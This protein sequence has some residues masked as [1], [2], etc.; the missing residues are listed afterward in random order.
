[1]TEPD[2]FRQLLGVKLEAARDGY[3][4]MSM[5]ITKAHLNQLGSAHGGAIFSLA[6]C[7]FGEAANQTDRPAVAIQVSINY[8][9]AACE[10]DLLVAEAQ[11]ISEGKTFCVYEV[12]VRK[13]DKAVALFTGLA[14]KQPDLL[15]TRG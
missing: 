14:Y 9:R 1:M 15:S 4:K 3:A 10:G 6:D 5:K 8:V 13:E 11:R 2:S 12:T 7:A